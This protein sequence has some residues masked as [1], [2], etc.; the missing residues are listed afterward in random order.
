MPTGQQACTGVEAV[1]QQGGQQSS[2]PRRAQPFHGNREASGAAHQPPERGVRA[3]VVARHLCH[4]L[5]RRLDR[6]LRARALLVQLRDLVLPRLDVARQLRRELRLGRQEVPGSRLKRHRLLFGAGA[7]GVRAG[8]Q[9]PQHVPRGPCALRQRCASAPRPAPSRPRARCGAP[10]PGPAGRDSRLADGSVHGRGIWKRLD[11]VERQLRSPQVDARAPLLVLDLEPG[12]GGWEGAHA[13]VG[14]GRRGREE[15][16]MRQAVCG[17]GGP[18][19]P[20]G[21]TREISP[22]TRPL[23]SVGAAVG[24]ECMGAAAAQRSPD[25]VT[26]RLRRT[27]ASGCACLRSGMLVM[28]RRGCCGSRVRC[29]APCPGV[30]RASPACPAAPAASAHPCPASARAG[31]RPQAVGRKLG[32]VDALAGCSLRWQAEG[33]TTRGAAL[34]GGGSRSS[35][36]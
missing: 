12:A 3:R 27:G 22:L 8:R 9:T 28:L 4:L 35:A 36:A 7:D 14:R 15:C 13:A 25:M 19:A 18:Q 26:A 32:R 30:P 33:L 10:R 21:L 23:A 5:L 31:G 1:A 17:A 24:R 34:G 20:T 29:H 2:G 16:R 11:L 6:G